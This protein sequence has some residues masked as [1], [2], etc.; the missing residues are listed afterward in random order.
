MSNQE[1]NSQLADDLAHL[2]ADTYVLCLK[3][4]NYHWNVSGPHFSSF[5]DLFQ[6]LYEMLFK[7]GD[8]IAER[9]RM[10]GFIAPGSYE[11]FSK[12]THIKEE[13]QCPPAMDMIKIL[14]EDHRWMI[15]S[16]YRLIATAQK[17][18]DEGTA[19]FLTGRLQEHEKVL[20]MLESTLD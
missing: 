9:I 16:I 12:L 20:W 8:A 3:T 7:A 4:Q 5:H 17:K 19:D 2:L 11:A 14:A 18:G 6:D 15:E 1:A 10:L 13:T